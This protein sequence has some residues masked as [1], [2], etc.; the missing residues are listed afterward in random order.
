M[1][2]FGRGSQENLS[3]SLSTGIPVTDDSAQ[4]IRYFDGAGRQ[5]QTR[6]RLG[7]G[8]SAATTGNTIKPTSTRAPE[9]N[10]M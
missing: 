8:G 5:V 3:Y 2:S 1:Y 9:A 10:S 6:A 4:T 7:S